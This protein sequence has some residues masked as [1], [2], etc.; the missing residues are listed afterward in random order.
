MKKLLNRLVLAFIALT[1]SL[2]F[3]GCA[4][5]DPNT[6]TIVAK[7]G[8]CEVIVELEV[9]GPENPYINMIPKN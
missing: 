8:D 4:D 7:S 3:A 5:R 6:A 2:W 9:Y 1:Q